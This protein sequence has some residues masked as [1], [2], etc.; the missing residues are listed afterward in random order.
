MKTEDRKLLKDLLLK[1]RALSLAVLID[2]KPYSGLLPFVT[3]EDFASIFVHASNMATHTAGLTENAPVSML[4]HTPDSA[5]ADPLELPRV[6]L[7]GFVVRLERDSNGYAGARDLYIDKFPDSSP[8]FDFTDFN[9]YQLNIE[10][11]RFV[12]GFGKAFNLTRQS[13]TDLSK[14]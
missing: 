11:A 14:D 4:I 13:I 7:D 1:Q 6:S 10:K 9:I 2:G 5:D 12:A 3:A 8:L